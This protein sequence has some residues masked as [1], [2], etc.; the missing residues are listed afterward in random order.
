M[1]KLID[2]TGH[3]YGRLTVLRMAPRVKGRGVEWVCKCDCGKETVVKAN[4]LRQ[5]NTKSCGCLHREILIRRNR[6]HG[7]AARGN[8]SRLYGIW[9]RMRQRCSDPGTEDYE[10]YGGRGITVCEEWQDFQAFHDWAC[11]NGYR[12]DFSIERI[13]ND[14][15]YEP[16]NC[17]WIPMERQAR[18]KRNN[19]LVSFQGKTKT[20]AEWAEET[21]IDSS[22]LRYRLKHW[23][24][25]EAL[26]KDI[27]GRKHEDYQID[28]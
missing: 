25:E 11:A 1:P 22:L 20:L 16:D 13:D 15:D 24:V 14:G 10:R 9:S 19:H 23:S 26:N 12:D 6:K 27:R 28:A 2:L 8:K 18:N 5:G 3:R 21:G 17:K 7:R 4:S